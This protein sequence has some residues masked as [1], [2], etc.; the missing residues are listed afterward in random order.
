M[1][2]YLS[3]P[4]IYAA[5]LL[6][7]VSG[8]TGYS[9]VAHHASASVQ[10]VG[11]PDGAEYRALLAP[12]AGKTKRIVYFSAGVKTPTANTPVNSDPVCGLGGYT[13][14]RA[15]AYLVGT[16]TGTAPTAA[17]KWQH[18]TD[19]GRHWNDIGTWTTINATVTPASQS[20]T[21][22][23]IYNATTAVAYGDCFRAQYTLGGTSPGINLEINGFA[24]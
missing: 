9:Q 4:L 15:D 11:D 3:R 23:D 6:S 18:S 17:I 1:R 8:I 22:S 14:F 24:K 13:I 16:M 10:T 5:L 20:Q 2:K 7:L 12:V 21:V 19:G